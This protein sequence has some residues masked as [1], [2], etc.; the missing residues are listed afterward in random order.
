MD[1]L[2]RGLLPR[3]LKVGEA[4]E[5]AEPLTWTVM[6][7]VVVGSALDVAEADSETVEIEVTNT[8]TTASESAELEEVG[9]PDGKVINVVGSLPDDVLDVAT[10]TTA[11]TLSDRRASPEASAVNVCVTVTISVKVS[12]SVLARLTVTVEVG[13]NAPVSVTV[14]VGAHGAELETAVAASDIVMVVP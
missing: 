5:V 11:R 13:V 14:S 12:T 7:E 6:T 8:V 10:G 3:N 9:R 2:R 1:H 4:V